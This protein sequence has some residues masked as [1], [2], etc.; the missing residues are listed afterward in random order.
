MNSGTSAC[1]TEVQVRHDTLNP[2]PDGVCH[3]ARFV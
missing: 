3:V 1:G 2:A